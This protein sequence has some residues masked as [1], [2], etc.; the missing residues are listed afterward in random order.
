MKNKNFHNI[1]ICCVEKH[2][3]SHLIEANIE[4]LAKASVLR[5]IYS[6]TEKIRF[7]VSW[8]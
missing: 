4:D 5:I 3:P 8:M 1:T 7:L 2:F 6:V